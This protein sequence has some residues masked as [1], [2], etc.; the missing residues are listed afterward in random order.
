MPRVLRKSWPITVLRKSIITADPL[1]ILYLP[2]VILDVIKS[3]CVLLDWTALM[4]QLIV[5]MD[6]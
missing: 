6:P 3:V 1:T 2:L 5:R 4:K